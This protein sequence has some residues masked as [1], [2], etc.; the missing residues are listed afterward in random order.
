[1]APTHCTGD[2]AIPSQS[3]RPTDARRWRSRV[4]LLPQTHTHEF[5][6]RERPTA[7]AST[8]AQR[9]MLMCTETNAETLDT[10]AF[11]APEHE[12]DREGRRKTIEEARRRTFSTAS[13]SASIASVAF[14]RLLSP[15]HSVLA[16]SSSPSAIAARARPTSRQRPSSLHAVHRAD[17]A[18]STARTVVSFVLTRTKTKASRVPV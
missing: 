8:W 3:V 14:G 10:A 16:L 11:Q 5:R 12:N 9:R 17:S 13:V 7:D 1:M 6:H 15:F 4:Q 18:A 2:R